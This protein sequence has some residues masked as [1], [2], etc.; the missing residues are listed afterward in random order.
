[1][2]HDFEV[3]I[4]HLMDILPA[5]S[6]PLKESPGICDGRAVHAQ[7]FSAAPVHSRKVLQEAGL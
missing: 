2:I 3:G 7:A 6:S 5:D 1:M 4:T